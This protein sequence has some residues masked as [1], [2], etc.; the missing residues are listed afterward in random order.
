[1][2]IKFTNPTNNYVCYL[3]GN[4]NGTLDCAA[5]YV[6]PNNYSEYEFKDSVWTR[7]LNEFSEKMKGYKTTYEKI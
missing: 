5:V 6:S 1:M 3:L 2:K 4:E 7:F